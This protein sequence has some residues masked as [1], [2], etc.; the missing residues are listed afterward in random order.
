MKRSAR[1][2]ELRIDLDEMW[3]FFNLEPPGSRRSMADSDPLLQQL[4]SKLNRQRLLFHP[5]K[6]GHPEAEK[7]FKF[8]EVCHQKLMLAYTR[9]KE[10]V[11]QRTR[12]EEE[13]LKQERME[14]LL[15]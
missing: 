10:S 3:G 15:L 7:T 12:R 5:D 1:E 6:N 4:K 13:E 8:L 9:Q 11:H 2:A 14:T